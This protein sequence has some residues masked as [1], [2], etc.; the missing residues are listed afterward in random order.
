M[1]RGIVVAAAEAELSLADVMTQPLEGFL[2]VPHC[3]GGRNDTEKLDS[4][5]QCSQEKLLEQ[6]LYVIKHFVTIG[7]AKEC[8]SEEKVTKPEEKE[9]LTKRRRERARAKALWQEELG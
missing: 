5:R 4:L 9:E 3:R 1:W 6:Q 8:L 2:T 7:E